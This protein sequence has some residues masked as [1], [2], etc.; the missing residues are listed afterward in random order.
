LTK[1]RKL[2]GALRC[3]EIP[4]RGLFSSFNPFSVLST[5]EVEPKKHL[6]RRLVN[7]TPKQVYDVVTDVDEYKYFVPWCTDSKVITEKN[8]QFKA[9]LGVGFKMLKEHYTSLVTVKPEE[10]VKVHVE[11]NRLFN[12]LV[13]EWIFKQGPREGT[14]W[15]EFFIAFQF[16][17]QMYQGLSSIFFEQVASKMVEAFEQRCLVKYGKRAERATLMAKSAA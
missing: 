15:L 11:D 6:E 14:T 13:N 2:G 10:A 1:E 9:E 4:R 5:A 7:F 16:K 3:H 17:N 8:G 12:F